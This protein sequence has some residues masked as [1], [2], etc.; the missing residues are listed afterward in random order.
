MGRPFIG[1][2]DSTPLCV[3]AFSRSW[4][5]S[6]NVIASPK[7]PA[8][9]L[10]P[11]FSTGMPNIFDRFAPRAT[12]PS[13]SASN[14]STV[15]GPAV[16]IFGALGGAFFPAGLLAGDRLADDITGRCYFGAAGEPVRLRPPSRTT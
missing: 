7:V 11:A 10:S 4:G 6:L 3:R 1:S 8:N 9:T 5:P 16:G 2:N 15:F 12:K 13:A 14:R